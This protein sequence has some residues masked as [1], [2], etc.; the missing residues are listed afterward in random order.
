MMILLRSQLKYKTLCAILFLLYFTADNSVLAQSRPKNIVFILA[1]DLGWSDLGCYGNTFNETPAI[2][3]LAASGVRFTNAY[4]SAPICSPTRASI[5]T[6]KYPATVNITD[7]IPGHQNYSGISDDHMLIGPDFYHELPQSETTVAERFRENGYITASI[8]KWHLGGKESTPKQHGFDISIG[9]NH[10]GIPPDYFFPYVRESSGLE[11]EDLNR[12]GKKGEYLTDRLT[13]E[14]LQFIEQNKEKPF[15]LYLSHYAV[16]TP[17]Q[18]KENMI[19]KYQKKAASMPDSVFKNPVYAAMLESLDQSV[20]AVVKK[21]KKL[22]LYGNTVLIFASDNGGLIGRGDTPSPT[23]NAP[24]KSGKA[25]LFEGGIRVPLIIRW[26]G[27]TKKG[28]ISEQLTSSVD[29]FPT[30]LDMADIDYEPSKIDGIPLTDNLKTGAI[31]DRAVFW[32]YP[33]YHKQGSRPSAAIRKGKWK[34]IEDYETNDAILYNLDEDIGE[35]KDLAGDNLDILEEMR[36]LLS[37]WRA[38]VH[39]TMPRVNPVFLDAK[40]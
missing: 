7:F 18:A 39:A 31:N 35:T 36:I 2:D 22:D 30:L 1:D 10:K 12:N 26:P 3:S 34:Y 37:G 9:G 28:S 13:D 6:G 5:L 40:K 27:T 17:M 38:K 8:G 15:M 24:L 25:F 32:H 4:A 20:G 14:A 16:H 11:L 21:L 29:F 33:H 19:K 23:T